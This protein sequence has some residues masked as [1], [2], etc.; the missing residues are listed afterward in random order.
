[1]KALL[2]GDVV[3]K[4]GRDAVRAL[5][6]ALRREFNCAFC[7]ANAE[8]CAGGAGLTEKAVLELMAGGVDVLTTGD[9]VWDQRE[10]VTQIKHLPFVLRPANLP[11]CQ[12]GV[13]YGVFPIPLGG[14]AIVINLL[15]RVFM[16]MSSDCPFAAV[17][18][19]LAEVGKRT[20]IVFVDVHGEATS[21][22]I[23]MGRYLDGRATAV[24][25]T[26]THV[27]TAD[28]QVFPK[29]TAYI[30]DVG[31][32]GARES[33]LGR[34]IGAVLTKF[35]TGMHA[36]FTVVEHGVTLHGAV[37]EFDRETGRASAITR[38]ARPH[39]EPTA[40]TART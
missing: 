30:T 38:V 23:A 7:I 39:S 31:M 32:V 2:I 5:A 27:E 37:V 3:G 34:E 1:M 10:F 12:P 15:L 20:P 13:G 40:A 19:I 29:G 8:N 4:G 28:E 6:P 33:I 16:K 11:A 18:R 17:D 21:E 26:H 36:R 22:K 9:H 35:T 14:E 25:G 24:F